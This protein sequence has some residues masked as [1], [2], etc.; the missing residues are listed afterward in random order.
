MH[1]FFIPL[2][3]FVV[4]SINIQAQSVINFEKNKS[5]N[6][7]VTEQFTSPDLA[8]NITASSGMQKPTVIIDVKGRMYQDL[9]LKFYNSMR[10]LTY[11]EPLTEATTEIDL[12]N[13]F[14][15][16]YEL[17]IYNKAGQHLK[18]FIVSKTKN[19]IVESTY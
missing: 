9:N 8:C 11:N 3:I 1:R 6:I 13:V 10:Q 16:K 2:F 7:E 4:Y 5:V 15:G 18:T 12:E 17:R 14:M 19:E